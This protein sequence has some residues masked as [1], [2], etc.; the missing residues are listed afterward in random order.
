MRNKIGI[1]C[2]IIGTVLI[3]LALFLLVYN[4]NENKK[5]EEISS[6]VV[7]EIKDEILRKENGDF[8]EKN[9]TA[10]ES[11]IDEVSTIEI[12]GN[13]Y[14]GYLTIPAL[15]LELPVMSEW[16]YA[17]LKIAPCRQLGSVRDNNLVIAGH[18]YNSHF[19]RLSK[20]K[21]EDIIIFTGI[22]G[23]KTE[24]S[25]GA[26]ETLHSDQNDAML[27]SEWELTLYT[28]TYSGRDRITIRARR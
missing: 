4:R 24:Y 10:E 12:D 9:N 15:N 25:V 22:N 6:Q 28:C 20:L 7:L 16:S 21:I 26:L 3:S 1:L 2:M 18:N 13:K 23:K 19:G 5:A 17:K 14:I 8:S 27:N 11:I